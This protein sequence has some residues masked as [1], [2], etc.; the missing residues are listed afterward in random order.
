MYGVPGTYAEWSGHHYGLDV[1]VQELIPEDTGEVSIWGRS[2][3]E[4]ALYHTYHDLANGDWLTSLFYAD[5]IEAGDT[6]QVIGAR[7]WVPPNSRVY[8]QIAGMNAACRVISQSSGRYNPNDNTPEAIIAAVRSAT[9]E[10]TCELGREWNPV[11]FDNP[12]TITDGQGIGIAWQIGGGEF[13]PA[14]QITP[15]AIQ[16]KSSAPFFLASSNLS[17]EKRGAYSY[18]NDEYW[19]SFENLHYGADL[20]VKKVEP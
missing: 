4:D 18:E 16:S 7:L 20:I 10:V 15:D 11:Y 9:N 13:Y 14:A 6:W 12:I 3:P 2:E 1:V 19:W 8:Q 17:G 5:G